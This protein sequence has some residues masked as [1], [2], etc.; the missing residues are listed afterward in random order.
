MKVALV[1]S[2]TRGDV[3]PF[4]CLARALADRGHA[5][6]LIAPRNAEEMARAAGVTFHGLPFDFQALIRAQPAQRMLAAGRPRELFRWL[7]E[8]G[9]TYRDETNRMLIG[10]TGS[11]ELIVCNIVSEA[12]CRSLAEARQVPVVPMHLQPHVLSWTYPSVWSGQRSLGALLNRL[13]HELTYWMGW[14]AQR[15]ALVALRRELGLSA[16]RSSTVRP[17]I[18]GANP[19]LLAYSQVLCPAPAGWPATLHPVGPLRP[20]PELRERL[21]EAGIPPQLETWLGAGPPPVLLGFGSMPV[22]DKGAMLHTIRA[23]LEAN[24]VRGILAAG[25]SELRE[26]DAADDETLTVVGEVDHDSLLPRCRAAVH[27]GGAGTVAASVGA[28]IPTLVC[29]VFSDQP[30]WGERCRSL[31]IGDTFRFAK[32]DARRLA[33][34]LE[35]VLAP[36]VAR[37]AGEVSGRMAEEGGGAEAALVYLEDQVP[38][39]PVVA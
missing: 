33:K 8:Q 4:L 29:S 9:R 18:R 23:A 2:G 16:P 15:E 7:A 13:S 34:G 5:V 35:A 28:G 24:G 25:W 26:S 38:R 1:S 27:H 12:L 17:M 31:G 19:T 6:E 20:G 3:Q 39:R 14:R 32:L 11:A 37:R 21:G 36:E 30:F 10:A 22:L